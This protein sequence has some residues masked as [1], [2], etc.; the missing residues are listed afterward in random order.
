MWPSRWPFKASPIYA[1]VAPGS[2]TDVNHSFHN[3][4]S[5]AAAV[6]PARCSGE[7]GSSRMPWPSRT[8][9][10]GAITRSALLNLVVEDVRVLFPLDDDVHLARQ[11]H[12]I[13]SG[14]DGHVQAR[15]PAGHD[16]GVLQR[17]RARPAVQR[18]RHALDR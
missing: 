3:S 9:G 2:G 16:A 12:Q 8:T 4:P 10:W 18:P 11:S 5:A 17:E 15:R 7:I 6:K 14:G 13:T 1:I